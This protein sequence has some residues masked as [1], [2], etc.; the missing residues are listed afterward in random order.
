[1]RARSECVDV[2]GVVGGSGVSGPQAMWQGWPHL[3]QA[4]T[5]TLAEWGSSAISREALI[6]L[7][8]G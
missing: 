1:M 5:D 8:E 7:A 6:L 2:G 3:V 4:R